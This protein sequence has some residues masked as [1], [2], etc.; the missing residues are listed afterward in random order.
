[1]SRYKDLGMSIKVPAPNNNLQGAEVMS[2]KKFS[3]YVQLAADD[4]QSL[5]RADVY[6]VLEQATS[7][8]EATSLAKY[9]SEG[10]PALS[11]EVEEC[12]QDLEEH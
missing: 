12:L 8:R 2:K 10:A 9:I 4:L 5:R 1:M 6:R 3:Q 11:D 7:A